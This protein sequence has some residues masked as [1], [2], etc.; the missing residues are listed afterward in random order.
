MAQA[1]RLSI[2]DI[3]DIGPATLVS[4]VLLSVVQCSV[5]PWLA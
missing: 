4:W 3:L 1:C 2:C 5:G